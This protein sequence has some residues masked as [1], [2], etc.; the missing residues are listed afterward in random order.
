MLQTHHY[1]S[2]V[3]VNLG[4]FRIQNKTVLYTNNI[5]V[6]F[7]NKKYPIT[8]QTRPKHII[9]YFLLKTRFLT[10]FKYYWCTKSIAYHF[11]FRFSV[12]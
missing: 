2:L 7:S 10:D 8:T 12:Q 1:Q 3:E 11:L 5:R 6:C 9:I 4:R